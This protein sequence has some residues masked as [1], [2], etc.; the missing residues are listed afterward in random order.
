[1]NKQKINTEKNYKD[2][3]E[4]GL[5]KGWY[6]NGQLWVEG[7]YKDD[8]KDGS[9]KEWYNN[10]QLR[11]E[12]NYKDGKRD[13]LFKEWYKKGDYNG[14][15]I[16]DRKQFYNLNKEVFGSKSVKPNYSTVM[17]GSLR[18]NN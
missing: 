16:I 12:K 7:N 5:F 17:E 3:K 8:K 4:N 9:F 1:M 15:I 6:D 10:S 11:Y 13:E 2:R 18:K 14:H